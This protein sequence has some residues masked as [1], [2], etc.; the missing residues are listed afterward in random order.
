DLKCKGCG[1][2]IS[3]CP[4]RAIDLKYYRDIQFTQEIKGIGYSEI[5]TIEKI[6]ESIE[7]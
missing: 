3:S 2:C 4:A 7:E 6:P 5:E 1:V